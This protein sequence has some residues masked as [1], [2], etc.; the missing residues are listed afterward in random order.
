MN[1]D[2]NNGSIS[3][4]I[5]NKIATLTF[6]HPLGNSFPG[7]LLQKFT[8]EINRLSEN[9]DVTVIV[10]KSEGNGPFCGGASFQELLNIETFEDGKQFFSGFANVINA[11]RKCTK[12]IIGNVQGK[13]VGG[14]VGL[15]AACD[16]AF[17]TENASIKLSELTIGIGPFVIE[18]VVT[19]KIGK[20]ALTELSLMA[21]DWKDA[22]WAKEKGL[23]NF[24]F[25]DIVLLEKNLQQFC[26]EL[27]NYNP[28][29]L[30]EMKKVFWENTS[31]WDDLL[32]ERAA[33]S[34]KLVLSDFTK[35]ALAGFRK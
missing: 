27:T 13:A 9:N 2:E 12:L 22:T 15:V 11:M 21:K 16:F 10:L 7:S 17:A 30:T 29:A 20:T 24:V 6:G 3:S 32:I 25:S 4:T 34:G 31:H 18:P 5:N 33:I 14:G 35:K 28:E 23:Y 1:L 19:K 8:F 26:E